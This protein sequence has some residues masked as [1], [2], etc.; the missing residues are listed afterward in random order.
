MAGASLT[1]ASLLLG[2][3]L[4]GPMILHQGA[5]R[6]SELLPPNFD[7]Q[8]VVHL[9]DPGDSA[10]KP[11]V[12]QELRVRLVFSAGRCTWQF[13]GAK[14]FEIVNDRGRIDAT[15]PRWAV[16]LAKLGCEPF[17]SRGA[18]GGV[19]EQELRAGGDDFDEVALT[20]LFGEVA[21]VLGA[22]GNGA[23]KT[24]LVVSKRT[25][26]PLRFWM[27]EH[28]VRVSCDFR[29]YDATFHSG[30]FPR[31]MDLVAGDTV[32]AS[33]VSKSE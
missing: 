29:R 17:F 9:R 27:E 12:D 7:V 10:Q 31:Q 19:L 4:P 26:V 28:G 14:P 22:G 11:V 1:V 18:Q 32:V 23:G 24:G 21:Y 16:W 15:E 2:Y 8:G 25:L 3:L 33:F 5:E 13:E 30:G 6:R 20:R